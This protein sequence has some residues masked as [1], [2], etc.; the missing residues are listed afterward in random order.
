MAGTPSRRGETG[1]P[2]IVVSVRKKKG[3]GRGASG[4][5]QLV[6]VIDVAAVDDFDFELARPAG[7]PAQLQRSSTVIILHVVQL[8]FEKFRVGTTDFPE[9]GADWRIE[10][11]SA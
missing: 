2:A 5:N 4:D 10:C 6:A 1:V 7:R 9:R 8:R 3:N 11:D